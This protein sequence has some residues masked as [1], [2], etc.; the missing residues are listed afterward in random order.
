MQSNKY[1]ATKTILLLDI[2]K[3]RTGWKKIYIK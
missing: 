2:G 1:H 3:K